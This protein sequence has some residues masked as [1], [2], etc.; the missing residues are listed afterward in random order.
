MLKQLQKVLLWDGLA[1]S[2][3]RNLWLGGEEKWPVNPVNQVWGTGLQ[4]FFA[5]I[6][7]TLFE[8]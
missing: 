3:M 1:K 7:Y 5:D 8:S 6:F 4:F 2:Y